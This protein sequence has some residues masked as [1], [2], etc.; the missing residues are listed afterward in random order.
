MTNNLLPILGWVCAAILAQII[1][2]Q[3]MRRITAQDNSI[4]L[5]QNQLAAITDKDV[6][7]AKQKILNTSEAKLFYRTRQILDKAGKQNWHVFAQVSYGEIITTKSYS[8]VKQKRSYS[9]INSKRADLVIVDNF[10]LP[11]IVI[12]YQGAGH[13]QGTA[14]QRDEI[15]KHACERA[16][17]IFLELHEGFI[18]SEIQDAILRVT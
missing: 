3:Y 7:F 15:K 1:F 14:I 12:E 5:P 10:S 16:K 17:I 9:A 4:A 13:Y 6:S 18:D 11:Q 8:E 2:K